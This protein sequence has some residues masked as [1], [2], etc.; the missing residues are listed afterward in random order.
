MTVIAALKLDQNIT[1]GEASGQPNSTHDG[2]R[3]RRNETNLVHVSKP[4]LH[5]FCQFDLPEVRCTERCPVEHF[6]MNGFDDF[7]MRMAVDERPPRLYE[8]HQHV[9]IH[10]RDVSAGGLL[11]VDG[12]AVNGF[13]RPNWG[14][15]PTDQMRQ[16]FMVQRIGL[17]SVHSLTSCNPLLVRCLSGMVGNNDTGPRSF[18]A[19]QDLGHHALARMFILSGV[20]DHR[21][22]AAHVVDGNGSNRVISDFAKNIEVG[23]SG[24]NHDD[25]RS[26]T[27]IQVRLE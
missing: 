25:V 17:G 21:V 1:S 5:P 18:E 12:V 23:Q 9:S 22:F 26:F 11:E 4:V 8:I 7:W 16:R 6:F 2:F 19:C 20:H 27:L 24:F 10:V 13:E 15:D 3:A 14:V